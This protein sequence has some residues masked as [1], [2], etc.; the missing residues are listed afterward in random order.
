MTDRT[1][2]P[3]PQEPFD[4]WTPRRSR[5]AEPPSP[6]GPPPGYPGQAAS[7]SRPSGR[8]PA[9][10]RRPESAGRDRDDQWAMFSY[11]GAIFTW[12]VAPL[13]VYVLKRRSSLFVRQHAAQSFNLTATG[14][15]FA[16]CIAIAGGLLALDS[17]K[18]ALAIMVPLMVALWIAVTV[19]LVR[20]ASAASRGEF[21][22]IPSW[23]CVPM[24]G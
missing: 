12:L 23:I 8:P 20:A 13:V 16:L 15:L 24:I 4:V 22:E 21:Y 6:A 3:G 9:G 10:P 17:P 18:A 5:T 7:V 1:Q 2:P 19:Y 11:L 14:T